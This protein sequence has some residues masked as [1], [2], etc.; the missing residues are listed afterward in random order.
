MA[1]R[2]KYC[3]SESEKDT[4]LDDQAALIEAQAA[5]IKELEA[6]L[7]SPKKTPKNSHTPP[8]AG[9]KS[10]AK[11]GKTARKPRPSRPGTSRR[12]AEAPD[13][14]VEQYAACCDGCGADVS[15]QRQHVR[16]RYDHI[17]LPPIVP[18]TTRIARAIQRKAHFISSVRNRT[19]LC[20]LSWTISMAL[21][22]DF[23]IR[24]RRVRAALVRV[25]MFRGA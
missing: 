18:H 11:S 14:V 2:S 22:G 1:Q 12:L 4:L 15:G 23:D 7:A 19:A 24:L 5:R 13:E 6:K 17:D 20:R 10:N 25:K 9:R 21:I 3:L 8:S 16:H